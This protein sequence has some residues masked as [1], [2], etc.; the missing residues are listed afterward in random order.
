MPLASENKHIVWL[1]FFQNE[2]CGFF[3]VENN[4][5][6]LTLK[7]QSQP[8]RPCVTTLQQDV[9][10]LIHATDL[11]IYL[12]IYLFDLVWPVIFIYQCQ[13]DL[14]SQENSD[15]SDNLCTYSV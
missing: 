6:I 9:A 7:R 11:S 3:M 4:M 8:K 5:V 2:F 10:I 1:W 15:F 13:G 12:F 14:Y